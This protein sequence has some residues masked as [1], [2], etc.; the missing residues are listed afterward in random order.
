[1]KD[2]K[3]V[4]LVWKLEFVLATPILTSLPAYVVLNVI[5][6]VTLLPYCWEISVMLS[7]YSKS[8]GF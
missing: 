1:M 2:S 5:C 6:G 3:T 8:I 7:D 4:V